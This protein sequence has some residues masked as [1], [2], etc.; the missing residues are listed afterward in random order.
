MADG[1]DTEGC[2]TYKQQFTGAMQPGLARRQWIRVCDDAE[3]N[4]KRL[5]GVMQGPC[6]LQMR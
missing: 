5:G 4:E 2:V 3:A 1:I 6:T